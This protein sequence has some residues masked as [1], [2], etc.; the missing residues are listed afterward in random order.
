L[1]IAER[2]A[3]ARSRVSRKVAGIA[4]LIGSSS[5]R[6]GNDSIIIGTYNTR[7]IYNIF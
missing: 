2:V 7:E 1:K 4:S 6:V 3:V 5:V